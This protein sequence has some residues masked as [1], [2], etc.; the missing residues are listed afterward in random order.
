MKTSVDFGYVQLDIQ[1]VRAS[2]SGLYTCKV[3]NKLGEAV[4][5]TSIKVDGKFVCLEVSLKF[6]WF[7]SFPN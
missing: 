6:V 2:D 3:T 1:G 5:T 7:L 4:S